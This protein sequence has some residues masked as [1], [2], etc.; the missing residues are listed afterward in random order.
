MASILT[1]DGEQLLLECLLVG[2]AIPATYQVGLT[3]AVLVVTDNL[4]TAVAGEPSGFGYARITMEQSN[5]GWVTSA[6]D[7]GHWKITGKN[8]TWTAS[9]GAIGPFQ[10]VF[11]TD[12]T[13]VVGFWNTTATSIPDTTSFTFTPSIKETSA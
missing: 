3:N 5:V 6:L 13:I 1:N 10:N 11:L 9:G 2:R 12:G 4:A 8:V 7:S